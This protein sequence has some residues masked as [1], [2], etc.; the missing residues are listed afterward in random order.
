MLYWL[1]KWLFPRLRPDESIK[2][3]NTI[4]LVVIVTVFTAG[5]AALLIVAKYLQV[6]R[7]PW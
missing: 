7:S 5:L 2:R 3:L 4:I 1:A 6:G